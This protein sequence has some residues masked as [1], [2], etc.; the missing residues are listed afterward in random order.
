MLLREQFQSWWD[1]L[2][3]E[4]PTYKLKDEQIESVARQWFRELQF[5]TPQ[6]LADATRAWRRQNSKR[7]HLS[8]ILSLCGTLHLREQSV[9]QK[10][11][12][13]E[14]TDTNVCPCGCDGAR[15]AL[16][17]SHIVATRD[18]LSCVARGVDTLPL[19]GGHCV[20]TDYRGVPVWSRHPIADAG[21]LLAD[22]NEFPVAAEDG[23]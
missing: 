8:D 14:W 6:I 19:A 16:A 12:S 4:F 5:Q 20:G 17:L 1:S 21:A 23:P 13:E 9:A 3:A 22:P 15:W 10:K 11:K 7:P 18:K 2:N